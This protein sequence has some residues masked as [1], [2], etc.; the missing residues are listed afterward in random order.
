MSRKLILPT[1]DVLYECTCENAGCNE[2]FYVKS[3]F[4]CPPTC[5][6]CSGE[7][8]SYASD[9]DCVVIDL[10]G[11]SFEGKVET[12]EAGWVDVFDKRE[13]SLTSF[14]KRNFSGKTVHVTVQEVK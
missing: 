13:N 3:S 14:I 8:V 4:S 5:P 11:K 2:V 10:S 7:N 12:L 9:D 1:G 6:S